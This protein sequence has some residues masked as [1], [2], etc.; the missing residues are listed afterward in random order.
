MTAFDR[1]TLRTARLVLR[2]LAGGDAPALLELFSDVRFMRYWSTLPWTGIE[3]ARA[4]IAAD[5]A[6]LP[7]G[8]YLRLGIERAGDGEFLGVCSLF[9]LVSGSRRGEIGYGIAPRVWRQGYMREALS[10]L[11]DYGFARLDLNRLEADVDPRNAASAGIL[12]RLGFVREGFLR[13][14]WIVG[15]VVSDTALYGLLRRDWE[16]AHGSARGTAGQ[17]DGG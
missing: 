16:A 15:T 7:A 6:A 14:R 2:P 12:E 4:V 1:L 3:Q 11:I 8:D 9:N 13:E 10:A 5:R 17:R